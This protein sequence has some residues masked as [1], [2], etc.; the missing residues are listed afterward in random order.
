[1]AK[2]SLPLIFSNSHNLG[3]KRDTTKEPQINSIDICSICLH[4]MRFCR[5]SSR[6]QE[7]EVWNIW[8]ELYTFATYSTFIEDT[9]RRNRWAAS[10]LSV[11]VYNWDHKSCRIFQRLFVS[12]NLC[13][14]YH[15]NEPIVR[16]ALF[17][18]NCVGTTNTIFKSKN[19]PDS[20][21]TT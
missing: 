7:R 9:G 16:D 4:R 12:G 20:G 18:E 6:F 17:I 3:T 11:M 14:Q 19:S 1:M 10:S 5:I 8:G 15:W 2:V 13:W 21:D